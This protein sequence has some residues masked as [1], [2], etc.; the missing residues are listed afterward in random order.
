MRLC[1]GSSPGR[2]KPPARLAG[3]NSRG[4][5]SNASGLPRASARIRPRTRSIERRADDR[6]EQLARVRRPT[7]PRAADPAAGPTRRARA[8]RAP[9]TRAR[10]TRL[11]R[12]R[13]T[14]ASTCA[15]D[16]SSHWASST[17]HSSGSSSAASDSRLSTARLIRK[18]SGWA[19]ELNPKAVAERVALRGRQPLEAVQQRPAQ[20]MQTREREAPSPTRRRPR[21]RRGSPRRARR[22]NP[23]ARS[24]PVPAAPRSTRTRTRPRLRLRRAADRAAHTP[25]SGR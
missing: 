10:P 19:P 24:F 2:P 17:R 4:S 16:R 8:A 1:S 13:A 9:R 11:C 22:R 6:C 20:L 7:A 15:E 14:N 5:S 25:R 21:G 12:R 18:R 23:A 3:D